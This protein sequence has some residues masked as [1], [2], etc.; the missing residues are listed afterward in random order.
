MDGVDSKAMM[1]S[2]SKLFQSQPNDSVDKLIP[3]SQNVLDCHRKDVM[4]CE[5]VR[6]CV[7]QTKRGCV[8]ERVCVSVR[9]IKSV[10]QR[11]CVCTSIYVCVYVWSVYLR[12]FM[13]VSV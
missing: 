12:M 1:N 11:P 6:E 3:S 8:S 4:H 10:C 2:A 13:H 9:Q 5:C 7:C